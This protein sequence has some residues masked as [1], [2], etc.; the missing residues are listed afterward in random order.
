MLI[1]AEIA[2]IEQFIKKEQ[3][4]LG[5]LKNDKRLIKKLYNTMKLKPTKA[6][7]GE[8]IGLSRTRIS[9]ILNDYKENK[10]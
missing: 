6:K 3:V 10:K 9:K 7:L 1:N 2:K 8:C 4:T 5:E